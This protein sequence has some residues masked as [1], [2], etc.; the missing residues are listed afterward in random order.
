LRIQRHKA[1]IRCLVISVIVIIAVA[2]ALIILA[3][4]AGVNDYRSIPV[5]W[6]GSLFI[7]VI[8]P[9][10]F[11]FSESA[12]CL[13]IVQILASYSVTRYLQSISPVIIERTSQL[14]NA[15]FAG[16]TNWLVIAIITGEMLCK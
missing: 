9:C 13:Q 8:L 10:F 12:N 11:L 4:V 6:D 7:A 3:R 16:C 1:V 14:Q 15:E 2:I 5:P